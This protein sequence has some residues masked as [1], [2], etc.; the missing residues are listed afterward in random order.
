MDYKT[1]SIAD[2][3]IWKDAPSFEGYYQ[4]SSLGKVRTLNRIDKDGNDLTGVPCL[5]S[6]SSG[7]EEVIFLGKDYD[8]AKSY[9]VYRLVSSLFLE[10]RKH[11]IEVKHKNGIK[12]DNRAENLEWVG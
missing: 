6:E 7:G 3:E 4:V 8:P 5:C 11:K 12:T 9:L 1:N 10:N 2:T